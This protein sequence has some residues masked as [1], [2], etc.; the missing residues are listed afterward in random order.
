M[1]AVSD[2]RE[3]AWGVLQ[4]AISGLDADFVAYADRH[5]ERMLATAATRAFQD[6]I[7]LVESA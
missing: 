6:A 1:R 5:F 2:Y 3:A 4:Q 7:G